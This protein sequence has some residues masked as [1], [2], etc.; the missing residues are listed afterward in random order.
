MSDASLQWHVARCGVQSSSIMM[1]PL[2][3]SSSTRTASSPL[4]V[5]SPVFLTFLGPGSSRSSSCSL[6]F[7][8]LLSSGSC[9]PLDEGTA[10]E[11]SAASC[12]GFLGMSGL[13]SER[14]L[15]GF[16]GCF[17]F[18]RSCQSASYRACRE[19]RNLR[20]LNVKD[21][22]DEWLGVIFI[23]DSQEGVRLDT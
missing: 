13:S 23:G 18:L 16:S 19:T 8:R 11:V 4:A 15:T 17:S 20:F 12:L 2:P 22:V 3:P 1:A 6:L 7:F 10:V 9:F 21:K 14:A 5:E